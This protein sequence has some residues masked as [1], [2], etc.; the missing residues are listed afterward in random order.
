MQSLHWRFNVHYISLGGNNF[1]VNAGTVPMQNVVPA[2]KFD[3]GLRDEI[4][5]IRTAK[6]TFC[7]SKGEGFNAFKDSL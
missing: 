2:A 5:N 7:L 4:G 1:N 6:L 3:Q